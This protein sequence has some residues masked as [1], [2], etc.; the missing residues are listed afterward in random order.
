MQIARAHAAEAPRRE[1]HQANVL[2]DLRACHELRE[3][4]VAQD[5]AG[6]R[7][8]C[9]SLRKLGALH[10]VLGDHFVPPQITEHAVQIVA[11]VLDALLAQARGAGGGQHIANVHWANAGDRQLRQLGQ[12]VALKPG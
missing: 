6:A 5:H 2:R 8:D 1:S 12:R 4:S 3:L 10:G 11:Q 9:E 7:I